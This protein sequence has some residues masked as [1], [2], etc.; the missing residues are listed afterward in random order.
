VKARKG[1]DEDDEDDAPAAGTDDAIVTAVLRS[2]TWLRGVEERAP[3]VLSAWVEHS[4]R[5]VGV[6]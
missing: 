3:G 6:E 5:Y 2:G 4:G 1:D